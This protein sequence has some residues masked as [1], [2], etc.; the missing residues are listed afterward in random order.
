[1]ALLRA[2]ELSLSP[3]K[4]PDVSQVTPET[5]VC[6]VG[7]GVMGLAAA[8]KLAKVPNLR[9]M[10]IDRFGIGNRFCASNDFN[11]MFCFANGRRKRDTSP[12]NCD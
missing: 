7:G 12:L 9:I 10:I 11:R 2:I 1:M 3:V 8:H 5:E 6:I 4:Y